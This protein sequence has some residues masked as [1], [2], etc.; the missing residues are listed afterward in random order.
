MSIELPGRPPVLEGDRVVLRPVR[1]DDVEGRRRLGTDPEIVRM[2]GGVPMH[3]DWQ[4]MDETEAREWI[5]PLRRDPNPLH[6]VVEHEGEF[7]GTA[8][9]HGLDPV[10]ERARYAVGLHDRSLLGE[11]LGTEVTRLVLSYGFEQVGLHRI[12]LRVL[13]YN[14]RAIA[15]YRRC[16]FVEEGRE[17]D[18]ALIAGERHDDVIMAVLRP[19]WPPHPPAGFRP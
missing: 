18:A 4:P 8:R 19:D 6:W 13:A 10:D 12:D 5:E 3:H 2:F 16:G 1:D 17:R 9:L 14:E 7:L 11:G 15:C